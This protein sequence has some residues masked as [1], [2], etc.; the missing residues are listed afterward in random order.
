MGQGNLFWW[1]EEMSQYCSFD[2]GVSDE[3][4]IDIYRKQ[5]EAKL[6]LGDYYG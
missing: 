3:V 6:I 2:Q 1:V 5:Q 4:K